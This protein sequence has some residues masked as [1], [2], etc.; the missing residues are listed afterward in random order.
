MVAAPPSKEMLNKIQNQLF[1]L[2][3]IEKKGTF[4]EI[5]QLLGYNFSPK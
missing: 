2:K 3:I 1:E 4:V 5:M